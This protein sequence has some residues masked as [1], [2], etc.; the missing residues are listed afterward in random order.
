[1]VGVE[2]QIDIGDAKPFQ[3][4]PCENAPLKLEA[5]REEIQEML[6]KRV[7]V[8]SKSRFS[9]LDVMVPEKDGSNRKFIDYSWLNDLTVKNAYPLP[10]IGQTIHCRGQASSRPLI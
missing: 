7:I 2:H 10:R 9:R 8:L 4:K 6:D 1:M 3:I 5:I